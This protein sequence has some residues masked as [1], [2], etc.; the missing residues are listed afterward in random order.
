MQDMSIL[1][2]LMS[3]E[4]II[5]LRMN[6]GAMAGG[7][8]TDYTFTLPKN[9]KLF[10]YTDGVAEATN[11]A[12]ELY[13]MQRI[14]DCLNGMKDAAPGK[15]IEGIKKSVDEFCGEAEQFDD[16]TMLSFWYKGSE[17]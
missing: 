3:R 1:S 9:G 13:D 16:M 10:V 6:I 5:C 15:V 4:H 14:E 17:E 8:Y 12:G 2:S 11:E 7:E